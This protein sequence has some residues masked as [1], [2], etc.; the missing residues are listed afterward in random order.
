MD[1][2]NENTELLISVVM[3]INNNM[4]SCKTAYDNLIKVLSS[5]GCSAISNY[6]NNL[7][8]SFND[9]VSKCD[10]LATKLSECALDTE[11]LN[12]LIFN[13]IDLSN[14]IDY[15]FDPSNCNISSQELYSK[16]EEIRN[17]NLPNNIKIVKIAKL[18]HEYTLDWHYSKENLI[19]NKD[20]E[21]TI[22]DPKKGICCAT[23]VS[24]VLYLAGANGIDAMKVEDGKFNPHWQHNIE[25]LASKM[26]WEI[27]STEHL[28]QLQPGDIIMTN[29]QSDG[30]YGHVELYAGNNYVYTCGSDDDIHNTSPAHKTP[31][32][33]KLEGAYA[34]RVP[35]YENI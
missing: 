14:N 28:D 18:F 2:V 1:T 3:A 10:E 31:E 11:Q 6:K 12:T 17:S 19:Y 34:I 5:S 20:Y 22:E 24:A 23:G 25:R 8:I 35:E 4:N 13:D 15:T 29:K 16:A 26:H 32:E 27:I 30:T 33:Y 21:A 7:S 9:C